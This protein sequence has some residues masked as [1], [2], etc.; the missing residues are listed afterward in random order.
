[1]GKRGPPPTP[2][3]LLKL[4]GSWRGDLI[5]NTPDPSPGKPTRPAW[6]SGDAAKA[7]KRLVPVLDKAGM[8]SKVDGNAL[9]RYCQLWARWRD[10]EDFI[11]KHGTTY[12][13]RRSEKVTEFR[14]FPQVKI[15]ATLADQ[16]LRLE[17]H[18]GLTPSARTRLTSSD[19]RPKD[20]L[21]DFLSVK[22][23]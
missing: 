23:G 17:Q 18:F 20:D 15:A 1:M 9:G 8:L 13:I 5:D 6:L 19:D 4:R 7:W 10:A 3:A 16:L 2:K 14:P 12:P 22:H 21:E 11:A